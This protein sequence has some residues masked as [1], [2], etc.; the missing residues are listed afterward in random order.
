MQSAAVLRQL[1]NRLSDAF[2]GDDWVQPLE[3]GSQPRN[4]YHLLGGSAAESRTR[5]NLLVKAV[6]G[7]IAKRREQLDG[8]LFDEAVFGISLVGHINSVDYLLA[9]DLEVVDGNLSR[10]EPWQQ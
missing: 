7:F 9:C 2:G 8:G 6:R 4:Q 3:S 10:D 5:A 1:L